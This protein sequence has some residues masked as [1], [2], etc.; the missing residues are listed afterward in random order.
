[1]EHANSKTTTYERSTHTHST[2]THTHNH[3]CVTMYKG[4]IACIYY[5]LLVLNLLQC[6]FLDDSALPA[7]IVGELFKKEVS[8]ASRYTSL[9]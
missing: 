4:W 9:K 1:M 3:S 8:A 5:W 6:I 7:S 2:H